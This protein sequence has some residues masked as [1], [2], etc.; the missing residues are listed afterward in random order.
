LVTS[1]LLS[2]MVSFL[3]STVLHDEQGRL[4]RFRHA[5]PVG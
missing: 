3:G 2:D 1:G 5:Q 4:N